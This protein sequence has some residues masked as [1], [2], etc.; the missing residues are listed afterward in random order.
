MTKSIRFIALALSVSS[1][2]AVGAR[3]ESTA[4]SL[5][6]Y[7]NPVV[8]GATGARIV[9]G[10]NSTI[11]GDRDATVTQRYFQQSVGQEADRSDRSAT[12]ST[13]PVATEQR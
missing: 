8:P 9:K 2:S 6:A 11:A 3:A 5:P 4:S 1:L 7:A 12:V 10:N 13:A